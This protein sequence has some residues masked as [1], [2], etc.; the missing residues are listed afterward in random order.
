MAM[1]PK[2]AVLPERLAVGKSADATAG[3]IW[4]GHNSVVTWSE[5]LVVGGGGGGGTFTPAGR[6]CPPGQTRFVIMA[7]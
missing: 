7:L 3:D 6:L 2:T 4:S 5:V 1:R